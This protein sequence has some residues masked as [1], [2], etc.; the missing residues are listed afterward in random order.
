MKSIVYIF[1]KDSKRFPRLTTSFLEN[2]QIFTFYIFYIVVW[3]LVYL[4]LKNTITNRVKLVGFISGLLLIYLFDFLNNQEFSINISQD[5]N[6]YLTKSVND[7]QVLKDAK[8]INFNLKNDECLL[9]KK[10]V[11]DKL[12]KEKKIDVVSLYDYYDPNKN[13]YVQGN[14]WKHFDYP[15]DSGNDY[16]QLDTATYNYVAILLTI[17]GIVRSINREKFKKI[18]PWIILASVFSLCSQILFRWNLSYNQVINEFIIKQRMF[19]I[20]ISFG[21][22]VLLSLFYFDNI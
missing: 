2:K 22:S 17:G 7:Y 14:L 8:G 18:F 10:E 5:G 21:I 15:L 9:L 4:F 11:F 6:Y 19:L 1:N 16:N 12:V 20:S 13:Q 3:G